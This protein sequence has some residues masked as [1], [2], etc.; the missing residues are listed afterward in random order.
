[1]RTYSPQGSDNGPPSLKEKQG[2]RVK[3]NPEKLNGYVLLRRNVLVI[4][5]VD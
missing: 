2:K 5:K 3:Q 1:M 4:V